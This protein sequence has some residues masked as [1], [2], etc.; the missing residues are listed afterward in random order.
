[1]SI[2]GDNWEQKLLT[3]VDN[4]SAE[5]GDSFL[6]PEPEGH[7]PSPSSCSVYYQC[8]QG[9]AHKHTCQEGLAWNINTLQCD[10]MERVDCGLDSGYRTP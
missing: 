4:L 7:F 3:G 6:C 2:A 5:S 1:M 9:T 10:W 8:A